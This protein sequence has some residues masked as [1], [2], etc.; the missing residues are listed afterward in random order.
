MADG[1]LFADRY[2]SRGDRRPG[3]TARLRSRDATHGGTAAEYAIVVALI[4]AVIA[5][6]VATLGSEV[7]DLLSTLEGAF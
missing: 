1:P 3:R 5:A 6:V 7:L 2:R 4:A